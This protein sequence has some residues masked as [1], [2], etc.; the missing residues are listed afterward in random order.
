VCMKYIGLLGNCPEC[1]NIYFL[2]ELFRGM[3]LS[4]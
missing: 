3:R 1:L 4:A 2:D